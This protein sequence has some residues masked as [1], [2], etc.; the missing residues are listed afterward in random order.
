M[1]ENLHH[2]LYQRKRW[3]ETLEGACLRETNGLV[4]PMDA[5]IHQELHD[6]LWKGVPVL[7]NKAIRQVMAEMK[8]STRYLDTIDNVMYLINKTRDPVADLALH[9]IERQLPFIKEGIT[10]D[11]IS[12]KRHR[13]SNYRALPV[14]V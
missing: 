12:N 3:Q 5:E 11:R 10:C 2:I 14:L 1:K 8:H 13:R 6:E 7:G 4:V 9:A